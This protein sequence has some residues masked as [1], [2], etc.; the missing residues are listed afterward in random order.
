[1]RLQVPA[2]LAALGPHKILKLG[3][4]FVEAIDVLR[5]ANRDTIN[6]GVLGQCLS[7]TDGS[8]LEGGAEVT[9]RSEGIVRSR[10]AC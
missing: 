10:R 5:R 8:G 1:M 6:L 3:N 7:R 4:L 2:A 9:N